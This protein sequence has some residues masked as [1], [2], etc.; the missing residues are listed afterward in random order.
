MPG[1]GLAYDVAASRPSSKGGLKQS[2]GKCGSDHG[3]WHGV[4]WRQSGSTVQRPNTLERLMSTA[5][6]TSVDGEDAGVQESVPPPV[7]QVW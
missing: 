1:N 6:P 3:H 7:Q 4:G 2:F 5:G